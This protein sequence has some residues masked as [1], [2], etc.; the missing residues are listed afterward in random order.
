V[1]ETFTLIHLAGPYRDG[2]QG[3]VRCGIQIAD[4]R[5]AQ[6]PE[7]QSPPVGWAEGPVTIV[8]GPDGP[9]F[10][11][12]GSHPDGLECSAASA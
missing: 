5:L 12:A 9:V 7:G 11:Q 1:T 10:M 3:C 8:H 6:W 2:V 4:D